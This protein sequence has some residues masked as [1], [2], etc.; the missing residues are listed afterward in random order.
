[1]SAPKRVRLLGVQVI[2]RFVTDDGETLEPLSVSPVELTAAEWTEYAAAGF[3]S[4]RAALEDQINDP[5]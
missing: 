1:M 3:E 5:A 4:A 2:A